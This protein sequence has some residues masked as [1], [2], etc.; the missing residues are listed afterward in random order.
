MP[1]FVPYLLLAL[2]SIALLTFAVLN[3][4]EPGFIAL[5]LCFSGMVFVAEFWVLVVGDGYLYLPA[6]LSK[7]YYDNILGS[8]PSNLFII[9]ALALLASAYSLTLQWLV[10]LAL[11]LLGVEWV[12]EHL[13]IYRRLWW[14][15][16]Y[17]FAALLF[18]FGLARWWTGILRSGPKWVRFV[19]LWMISWSN[20]ATVMFIMS[21]A[22]LR[23][24]HYGFYA[25]IYR[26][27]VFIA[28]LVGF[29]KGLIFALFTFR[30]SKLGWR[31]LA[32]LLVY[33][34]DMVLYGTGVL[35][36]HTAFWFYTLIYLAIA[37]LLMIWASYA[38]NVFAGWRRQPGRF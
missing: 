37:S 12:F 28:S 6:V 21:V 9:P 23:F 38:N 36:I 19:S 25:G 7:P 3:K 34:V 20:A 26:D 27:D 33:A 10:C 17:T 5:F 8:F 11:S 35:V 32:P 16:E 14:R 4:R 18:F 1:N 22:G 29:V 30:F 2:L 31:L 15:R 24:Y 13:G